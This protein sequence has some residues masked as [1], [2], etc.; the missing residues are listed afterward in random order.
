MGLINNSG[1][2]KKYAKTLN[3][4][5]T[6]DII[7]RNKEIP[8]VNKKV[9]PCTIKANTD[10][11]NSIKALGIMAKVNNAKDFLEWAVG[12]YLENNLTSEE[13]TTFDFIKNQLDIKENE[14]RA[15]K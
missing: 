4:V 13:R 6:D 2:N 11:N 10:L 12:E 3:T 9:Y 14:K 5:T 1:V 7:K 15:K 8:K